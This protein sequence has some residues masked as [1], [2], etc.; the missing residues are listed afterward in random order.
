MSKQER[1]IIRLICNIS[2]QHNNQIW[3]PLKCVDLFSFV[4]EDSN[5]GE[6]SKHSQDG[7][8]EQKNSFYYEL[9]DTQQAVHVSKLF[10]SVV[11]IKQ[12]PIF[13]SES[14]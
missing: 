4:E 10:S 12:D 13:M 6:V 3:S 7:K 8:I 2:I 5:K 1:Q 14:Q 9:K 11:V